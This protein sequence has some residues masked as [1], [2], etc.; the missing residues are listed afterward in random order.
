MMMRY[1]GEILFVDA[2]EKQRR[3]A[4][5]CGTRVGAGQPGEYHS[6]AMLQLIATQDGLLQR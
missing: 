2:L 6:S 1:D 5:I 4:Y 3:F